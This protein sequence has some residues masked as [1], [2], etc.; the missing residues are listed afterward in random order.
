MRAKYAAELDGINERDIKKIIVT[1]FGIQIIKRGR[2]EVIACTYFVK[3]AE[4]II[5]QI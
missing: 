2:A 1:Y 5:L 3:P 4:A